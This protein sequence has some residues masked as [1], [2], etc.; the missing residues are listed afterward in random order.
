MDLVYRQ[1]WQAI[2]DELVEEAACMDES[3][4]LLTAEIGDDAEVSLAL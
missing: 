1:W 3:C 2:F 4:V